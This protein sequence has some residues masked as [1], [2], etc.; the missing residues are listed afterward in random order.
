MH[1]HILAKQIATLAK[2][3]ESINISAAAILHTLAG[4]LYSNKEIELMNIVIPFAEG[5]QRVCLNEQ[6]RLN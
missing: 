3:T 6:Y 1:K 5:E 2:N 4:A